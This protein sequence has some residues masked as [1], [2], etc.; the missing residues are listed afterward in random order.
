[1]SAHS[2]GRWQPLSVTATIDTYRGAP[3]RWWLSGGHAFELHLGRS[4]RHHDDTDVGVNRRDIGALPDVLVEWDLHIAAA[5]SLEPWEGGPLQASLHQNNVWCRR[6]LDG[7]WLLDVTIG[8]GHDEFWI[9]R[10]DPSLQVRWAQAVLQIPDGIPY[11]APE[12]Q[13]LFKSKDRRDK[14]DTDARQVIPELDHERLDQLARLLP[15]DHP[16]QELIACT[17]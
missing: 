9:Y 6:H 7:P 10:R 11:L 15:T 1:M 2:L 16:W 5:G 3:F 12:L 14:N 8:E 13:L 17:G 4:W